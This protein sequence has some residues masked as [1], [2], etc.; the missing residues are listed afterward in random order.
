MFEG[1]PDMIN[2]SFAS[3]TRQVTPELTFVFVSSFDSSWEFS[4]PQLF[5]F[6][7][8]KGDSKCTVSLNMDQLNDLYR[9]IQRT[10]DLATTVTH[11]DNGDA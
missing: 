11:Q 2:K 8:V 3:V 4:S 10:Q 9:L 1:I 5:Q 6:E 7:I